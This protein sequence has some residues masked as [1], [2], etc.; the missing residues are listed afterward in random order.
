MI[1]RMFKRINLLGLD[2]YVDWIQ[3]TGEFISIKEVHSGRIFV[4]KGLIGPDGV[5]VEQMFRD[6]VGAYKPEPQKE[7]KIAEKKPVAEKKVEVA[8]AA[9]ETEQP[10]EELNGKKGKGRSRKSKE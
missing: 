3:E 8:P 7:E 10:K 6:A 1:T 9:L 4:Y 2:F 5:L